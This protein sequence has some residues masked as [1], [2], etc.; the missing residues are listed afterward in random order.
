MSC[1]KCKS[2]LITDSSKRQGRCQA[3]RDKT[4]SEVMFI[5]WRT[6]MQEIQN[7]IDVLDKRLKENN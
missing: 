7:R 3:C 6:D 5:E 2:Q 4:W 1:D